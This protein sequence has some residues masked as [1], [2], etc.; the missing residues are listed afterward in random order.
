MSAV[1]KSFLNSSL[2]MPNLSRTISS[3]TNRNSMR[4]LIG[5]RSEQIN[6]NNRIIVPAL[7]RFHALENANARNGN[8]ELG[9]V[10]RDFDAVFAT[11]KNPRRNGEA[12][13]R[14]SFPTM[15]V[16]DPGFEFRWIAALRV[17][18]RPMLTP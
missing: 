10:H 16:N 1:K 15:A 2:K 14:G 17:A 18:A 4:V 11:S 6:Q 3:M 12:C 9:S 13:T 8:C 5:A 7:L